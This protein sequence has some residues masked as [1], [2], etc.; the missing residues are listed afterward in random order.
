MP[1]LHLLGTGAALSHAHRTTTML[2]VSDAHA[3]EASTLV[4]DC[5]GDVVQRMLAAGL[6]LGDLAGLVVTHSH[7]DHVSGFPLFVEK[8]WLSGRTRAMP[9]CG[10]APAL[11]QARRCFATFDTSGWDL[12]PLDYRTV[13]HAPDA[14]VWEAAPWHVTAAPVAHFVPNIGLRIEHVRT[15]RVVAYSCDTEPTDAVIDL[16]RDADVLVHEATGAGPGHSSAVQ[17]AEQAQ[18]AGVGRLLLVHLPDG[19]LGPA[20]ADARAVFPDTDLGDELGAY[21]F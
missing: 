21:G 7:P 6:P 8:I 20:L 14:V 5:G 9:V 4:V 1:T 3:G 10:I 12:P 13:A 17:A 16:A 15:G 18:A 2:A 11:D 19:D